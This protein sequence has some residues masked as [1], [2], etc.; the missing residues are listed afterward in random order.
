MT[1]ARADG[2]TGQ[3]GVQVAEH[4]AGYVGLDVT[5]APFGPVTQRPLH[6]QHLGRIW[7]T[8]LDSQFCGLHQDARPVGGGGHAG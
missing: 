1:S 8:Q 3:N 4:G 7:S 2:G 5:A 6:V